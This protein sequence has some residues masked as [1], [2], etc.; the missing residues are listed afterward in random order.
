MSKALAVKQKQSER[1]GR[2]ILASLF[3]LTY[4]SVMLSS[5][6]FLG[7]ATGFAVRKPQSSQA[8]VVVAG[9]FEEILTRGKL[10]GEGPSG[11]ESAYLF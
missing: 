8:T 6:S 7:K 4:P 11:K 3:E 9:S 1:V 5:Q 10:H 2:N